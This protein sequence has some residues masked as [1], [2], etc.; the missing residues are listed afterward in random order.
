AFAVTPRQYVPY[1]LRLVVGVLAIALVGGVAW[2]FTDGETGW[3]L[4]A[5]FI[6]TAIALIALVSILYVQAGPGPARAAAE[7]PPLMWVRL[8]LG[9][10]GLVLG[11]IL[12]VAAGTSLLGDS[13]LGATIGAAIGA[14]LFGTLAWHF[15][16]MLY[17]LVTA[18]Y[19]RLLGGVPAL[20]VY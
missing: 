6:V 3:G 12:G 9:L 7:L 8:G 17:L 2:L 14:A 20:L 5:G 1:W 11:C 10:I 4:T 19:Y 16:S 15:G 13:I 18:K